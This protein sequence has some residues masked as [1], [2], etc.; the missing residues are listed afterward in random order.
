MG[1]QPNHGRVQPGPADFDCHLLRLD[2][3]EQI[4]CVHGEIDSLT[5][6]RLEACLDEQRAGTSRPARL[7]VAL[8]HTTFLGARA[9]TVL[10]AAAHAAQQHGGNLCLTGC[11]PRLL[12]VL[13]I[14]GVGDALTT[15]R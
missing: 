9:I 3:G 5:A 15:S 14:A 7:E 10:L 8:V 13:D 6:P 4:V 12:R 1:H 11:S 2:S